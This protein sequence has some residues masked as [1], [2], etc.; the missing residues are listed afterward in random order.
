MSNLECRLLLFQEFQKAFLVEVLEEEAEVRACDE[1]ALQKCMYFLSQCRK[2]ILASDSERSI[3]W[4][5]ATWKTTFAEKPM[6]MKNAM[7]GERR[8]PPRNTRKST[9]PR[10]TSAKF[11]MWITTV[12]CIF[13]TRKSRPKVA[14]MQKEGTASERLTEQ[15]C[16]AVPK[17]G[18]VQ[19]REDARDHFQ[20]EGR[21][22]AEEKV[23]VPQQAEEQ[24][25]PP[26]QRVGRAP[27]NAQATVPLCLESSLLPLSRA[28]ESRNTKKM[29]GKKESARNSTSVGAGHQGVQMLLTANR[30]S[31]IS[32]GV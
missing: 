2:S 27:E 17:H 15:Q 25:E 5:S 26:E 11:A 31:S 8:V 32:S 19:H 3:S 22:H 14:T 20:A 16:R 12:F 9:E 1:R 10:S 30:R 13:K 23:R 29:K 7:S 6:R 4:K 28:F 24:L 21:Q 18:Q